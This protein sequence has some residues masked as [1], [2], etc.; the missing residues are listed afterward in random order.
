MKNNLV[1]MGCPNCGTVFT[2]A[3][4]EVW[5]CPDCHSRKLPGWAKW[6]VN[7]RPKEKV[8][9]KRSRGRPKKIHNPEG[10]GN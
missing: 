9:V 4:R 6:K 5:V 8:V 7:V 2:V 10:N 1:T 3:N